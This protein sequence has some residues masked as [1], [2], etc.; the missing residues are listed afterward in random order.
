MEAI[1]EANP[2]ENP[3]GFAADDLNGFSTGIE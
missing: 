1:V 3:K 2:L